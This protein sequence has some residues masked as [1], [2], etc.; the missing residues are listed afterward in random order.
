MF[1]QKNFQGICAIH[2]VSEATELLRYFF[3]LFQ[4]REA[5]GNPGISE[6]TG[7]KKAL[8]SLLI[9]QKIPG[10]GPSCI[11]L[12]GPFSKKKGK[13]KPPAST[14]CGWLW[15]QRFSLGYLER[16]GI[17]SS[18]LLL[19][20]VQWSPF[21]VFNPQLRKPTYFSGSRGRRPSL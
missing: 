4:K 20:E 13:G 10:R 1:S 14:P 19:N 12:S 16:D 15:Q 5:S 9:L 11:L 6:A 7:C 21:F 17:V 2:K 18:C 3:N 8:D